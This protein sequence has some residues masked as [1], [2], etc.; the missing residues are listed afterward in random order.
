MCIV[1]LTKLQFQ[2]LLEYV[3]ASDS[4]AEFNGDIIRPIAIPATPP[5][6]RWSPAAQ[7]VRTFRK[8]KAI[9]GLMVD[10]LPSSC[11]F[12]LTTFTAVKN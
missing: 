9:T 12:M 11:Y 3:D 5:S 4:T 2:S 1:S 6:G 7:V 8:V 10:C